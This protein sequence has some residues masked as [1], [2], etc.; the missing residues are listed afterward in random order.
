MVGFSAN[1]LNEELLALGSS[2]M[3]DVVSLGLG[4]TCLTPYLMVILSVNLRT[5]R[6]TVR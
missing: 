6:V 4:L 3:F 2:W 5:R 1:V